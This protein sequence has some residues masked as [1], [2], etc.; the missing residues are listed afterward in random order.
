[1]SQDDSAIPDTLDDAQLAAAMGLV[2]SAN[3]RPP[4]MPAPPRRAITPAAQR[5]LMHGSINEFARL[6][7][8]R[9][10]SPPPDTLAVP[11]ASQSVPKESFVS[12]RASS[13]EAKSEIRTVSAVAVAVPIVPL[14]VIR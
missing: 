12:E 9:R 11:P 8:L 2:V 10:V 4:S 1:V 3:E 14:A 13:V 5:T 7:E 6:S